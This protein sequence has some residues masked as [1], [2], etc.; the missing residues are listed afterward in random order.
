MAN[1]EIKKYQSHLVYTL[2]IDNGKQFYVGSHNGNREYTEYGILSQSGNL[3]RKETLVTHD[4]NSYYSRVKL[5]RV[6]QF[7][8]EEDAL[9]REQELLDE[10]FFMLPKDRILNVRKCRNKPS[11]LYTYDHDYNWK[12]KYSEAMK[13]PKEC[14][15]ER[16]GRRW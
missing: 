12:Q 15:T 4:W 7:D 2:S 13:H 1:K 14:S 11:E 10:M 3:I 16:M 5:I 9:K 6:E 8:N